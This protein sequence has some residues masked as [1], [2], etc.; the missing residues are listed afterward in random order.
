MPELK[1]MNGNFQEHIKQIKTAIPFEITS[2]KVHDGG[3]DFL[4]I[5]INSAWMFRFPRNDTS[6]KVLEK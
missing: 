3:D 2:A 5:E 4:V 6:Q 1:P